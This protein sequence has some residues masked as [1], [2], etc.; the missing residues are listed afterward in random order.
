MTRLLASAADHASEVGVWGCRVL[1]GR[2]AKGMHQGKLS[3]APLQPVG[4]ALQ[5]RG[6]RSG[7]RMVVERAAC[8]IVII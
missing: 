7:W 6:H 1:A 8:T 5:E 3:R 2:V 4:G